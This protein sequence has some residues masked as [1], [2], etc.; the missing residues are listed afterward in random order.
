[1]SR[2]AIIASIRPLAQLRV[3]LYPRARLADEFCH[4][5]VQRPEMPAQPPL[6]QPAPGRER[7]K[8][9]PEKRGQHL[10]EVGLD[11]LGVRFERVDVGAEREPGGDVHRVAHQVGLQVDRFPRG[12]GALPAQLESLGDLHQRRE[13]RLDVAGIEAR[14]HHRPLPAPGLAARREQAVE[15]HVFRDAAHARGAPE[16]L[17]TVAQRGGDGFRVRQHHQLAR[18]DAKTERLAVAA[19]PLLGSEVQARAVDLQRVAQH[20]QA[21]RT[22]KVTD[23]HLV[24]TMP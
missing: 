14:H 1:V 9:A 12:R 2:A 3:G 21:A 7:R 10:V 23:A 17:R 8:Q 6:L 13:I 22:R 19:A 11:H 5:G 20:R 15:A 16:A 24:N 4:R 18:A